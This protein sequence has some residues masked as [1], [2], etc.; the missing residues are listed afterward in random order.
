ML[1]ASAN[2][3]IAGGA[4]AGVAAYY[5]MTRSRTKA[6]RTEEAPPS[7]PSAKAARTEGESPCSV[8]DGILDKTAGFDLL[9]H[10]VD[11]DEFNELIRFCSAADAVRLSRCDHSLHD[12][13]VDPTTAA[14]CAE[15]R[16]ALLERR[17][18]PGD[19]PLADGRWSLERLHLCERPPRFLRL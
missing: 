2:K 7:P 19:L 18:R 14:W 13:I 9:F 8:L 10:L 17:R 3:V 4:L 16:R 12:R 1:S 6:A 5:I 11:L 15:S